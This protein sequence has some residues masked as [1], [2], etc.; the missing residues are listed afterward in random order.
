MPKLQTF[1]F[2]DIA[3]SVALK[4]EM[5]GK[6]D[7]ERDLA[8]VEQILTPHRQVIERMLHQYGGRVVSTAGDGHFLVFSNTVSATRWAV[9]VQKSHQTSPILT[10]T[11]KPVQVRISLHVGVP[12][13]DPHDPNNFIGKPVDYTARLND[14]TNG[15]QILASRSVMA[16]V[17]DAGIDEIMF[18]SHGLY[19]L[20]G[21]GQIEIYE[22]VYDAILGPQ[23]TRHK[24]KETQPREWTVLPAAIGLTEYYATGQEDD[25]LVAS[26]NPSS[27]P[28]IPYSQ[29]GN[30]KLG[31]LIGSG[32]MGNV[33]KA[34]H[35]QFGRTRAVKVIKQQFVEAGHRDIVR[36]FYQEIKVV[37]LLEHPN[38]I[39]AIESS[40]PTEPVH[41][42][43]MEYINGISTDRLIKQHGPLSVAD[44]CEIIR[45]AAH[46][47]EY[48]H[49]NGMV[50][51]DIKPSNLMVTLTETNHSRLALGSSV[52]LNTASESSIQPKTA[53]P[54]VK[55]LDL[56]LALLVSDEHDR[57]TRIDG[58]GM[59]TSMYMSPEQWA[60]TTVDIRADIYSL[61]CTL[62]HLLAGAPPFITSELRPELA[63]QRE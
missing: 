30:Y 5:H 1:I 20:R 24:P 31:E 47:L 18:H 32:G 12:Q 15:G 46:G 37:G 21:I 9:D 51:R 8:Y 4:A 22:L 17:E 6:S 44:A 49:Q 55:I 39:V 7:A 26:K 10:P 25:S 41:Y 14:Y 60:S 34:Q 16:L 40:T 38:L 63:H 3:Q 56:G 61:G 53:Q 58:R 23:K 27:T 57:L 19:E 43:V 59:G 11:Q 35:T 54:V 42:L 45:Q 48:I 29:L 2:T 36:R 28:S 52:S 33:Y 50:H 13:P 62:Y